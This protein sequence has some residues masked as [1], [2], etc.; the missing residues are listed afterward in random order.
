[1]KTTGPREIVPGAVEFSEDGSRRLAYNE[2]MPPLLVEAGSGAMA[3][4]FW[5]VDEISLGRLVVMST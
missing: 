3:T 5:M 2:S 1:L 4:P